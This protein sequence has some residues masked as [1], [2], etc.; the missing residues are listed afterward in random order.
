MGMGMCMGM[1][2]CMCMGMCIDMFMSMC[3]ASEPPEPPPLLAGLLLVPNAMAP[4]P[5]PLTE[6]E[7]AVYGALG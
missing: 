4:A 7:A 5:A 2:M 3:Q 6:R 1:C